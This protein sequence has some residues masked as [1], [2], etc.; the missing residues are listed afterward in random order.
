V[1]SRVGASQGIDIPGRIGHR[2]QDDKAT[3]AADR[4]FDQSAAA[5]LRV[6]VPGVAEAADAHDPS[7]TS[8]W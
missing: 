1:S 4:D 2:V 5:A 3:L 7:C 8:S 6:V